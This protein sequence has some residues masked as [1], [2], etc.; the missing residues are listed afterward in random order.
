MPLSASRS[1]SPSVLFPEKLLPGDGGICIHRWRPQTRIPL[2]RGPKRLFVQGRTLAFVAASH[3]NDKDGLVGRA[4]VAQS[5]ATSPATLWG[6][7]GGQTEVPLCPHIREW[8]GRRSGSFLQICAPRLPGAEFQSRSR[9][10][11]GERAPSCCFWGT[12]PACRRVGASRCCRCQMP[13]CSCTLPVQS[14]SCLPW[15]QPGSLLNC[16]I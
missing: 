1:Q 14:H 9:P 11:P 2:R 12:F 5:P 16:C 6:G 10:T 7:P 13:T 8:R 3:L 15:D 4:G